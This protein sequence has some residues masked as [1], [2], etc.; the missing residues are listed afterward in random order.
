[1]ARHGS[2]DNWGFPAALLEQVDEA[3]PGNAGP[4]GLC[5][6]T[7]LG[8]RHRVIDAVR[9]RLVV[10]EGDEVVDD[11]DL[12]WAWAAVAVAASYEHDKALKR[13]RRNEARTT[14]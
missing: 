8:G 3:F 1:M 12:P 14:D 11:Y 5:G 4:C 10:G 13:Q 7:I 2:E 9:E 6:D